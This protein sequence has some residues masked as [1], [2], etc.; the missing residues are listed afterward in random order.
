MKLNICVAGITGW[1]GKV[2]GKAILEAEDL[3]LSGAVS[4]TAAGKEVGEV[5]GFNP[6]GLRVVSTV[7]EALSAPTDV[8]IDYTTSLAVKSHVI[9]A[10]RRNV[11]VVVGTSGLT[12]D[13][14]EE[15]EKVAKQVPRA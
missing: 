3:N 2:L 6:I 7:E 13:D 11:S 4:R 10:L 1:V 12:G 5:L 14:Y 9:T 8:L 15:I